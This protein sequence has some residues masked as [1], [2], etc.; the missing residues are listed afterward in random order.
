MYRYSLAIRWT[1]CGDRIQAI[2]LRRIIVLR[3]PDGQ[4]RIVAGR[5]A[6]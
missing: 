1:E 2:R 3:R 6:V 4:H 5:V